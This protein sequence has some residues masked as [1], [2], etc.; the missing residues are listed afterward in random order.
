MFSVNKTAN[1]NNLHDHEVD[2]KISLHY[3]AVDYTWEQLIRDCGAHVMIE[4]SARANEIFNR[5][6][7]KKVV[8]WKGYF[9]NAYLYNLNPMGY[10]PAHM[11]NINIRMIPSESLKNPDLFLSLDNN[12][13]NAYRDVLRQFKTGDPIKFTAS[14][15]GIGNEWRAHHLNLIKLEKTADFI[16]HEKKVV[17]FHGINFN[18]TGHLQLENEIKQ[19]QIATLAELNIKISDVSKDLINPSSNQ[20]DAINKNVTIDETIIEINKNTNE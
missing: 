14:L 7:L 4:N 17:L 1:D 5:Q 16:D 11:V 18:I 10:N 6:Y 8:V 9:L 15:E 2:D 12:R 20:T 13:F 3:A 19:L